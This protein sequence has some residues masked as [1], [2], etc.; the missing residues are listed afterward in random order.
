MMIL[1]FLF[2]FL[3]PET[4]AW[5]SRALTA[6]VG[7]FVA[8]IAY[9]GYRRNGAPKML[10]LGTGIALLTAGVFL[11]VIAVDV[12]GAGDGLVLLARGLVSFVGLCAILYAF[13]IDE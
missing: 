11:V 3:T 5:A 7:L 6:G 2:E 13:F 10:L 4:V 8:G 1:Y 12:V 9:R